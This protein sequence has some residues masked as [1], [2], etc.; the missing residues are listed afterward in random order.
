MLLSIVLPFAAWELVRIGAGVSPIHMPPIVDVFKAGQEMLTSG[1]LRS[2][3]A[4]S[5]QRILL[6]FG[7]SLLVSVPLGLAMGTFRGVNAL[8]EPFVAF[9]RYMP[10]TAFI[11][12]MLI[13]F[14]IGEQPKIALIFLGTVFFNTLMTAN[15]VWQIP[16]EAIRVAYTLGA[17]NLTVMRKV[18]FPYAVPGII[19]TAR[20]N[21]AAA[22]NLIVVAE[23]VAAQ[24]GLG[25]RIFREQRFLHTDDIFALLIVIGIIGLASDNGLRTLRN[26]VAPWSQE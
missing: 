12:L 15:I 18:I 25:V 1:Q 16:N 5:L 21:L 4:A 6:G 20:V 3:T 19:D 8:F 14:G 17:N 23:L 10:A 2:D 24:E 26:R 9:V 22:W 11:T 7:L 13:W